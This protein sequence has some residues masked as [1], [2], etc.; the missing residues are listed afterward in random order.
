[1]REVDD[2]ARHYLRIH[3]C[4]HLFEAERLD[5]STTCASLLL[6]EASA[7]V[8]DWNHGNAVH[9]GH[10]L[11][12][13][14]ALRRRDVDAA[15]RHLSQAGETPGSP[16]LGSYGPKMT[17]AR[18]LLALGRRDAVRSYLEACR[19]F[20]RAGGDAIDP[21]IRFG[22]T[23]TLAAPELDEAEGLRRAEEAR[24]SFNSHPKA[25][26]QLDALPVEPAYARRVAWAGESSGLAE[27][28]GLDPMPNFLAFMKAEAKRTSFT[29]EQRT[30]VA[31]L[32]GV[33]MRR[34]IERAQLLKCDA[35]LV[36]ML[37]RRMESFGG[38]F[39]PE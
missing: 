35:R 10:A 27:Y 34:T 38:G 25:K 1:M 14:I 15:E 30:F 36:E 18:E 11:L 24:L 26:R 39:G 2:S 12:G 5:E 6:E 17:L 37:R 33:P 20:W 29:P 31:M 32:H 4:R 3:H 13:E 9:D 23:S 22:Q 28:C 16:Q 21:M 8:H 19:K 7:Q